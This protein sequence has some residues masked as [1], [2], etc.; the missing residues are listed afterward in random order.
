[1]TCRHCSES[2]PLTWTGYCSRVCELEDIL[3]A[4]FSVEVCVVETPGSSHRVPVG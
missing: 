3:T 4:F 1:M 2:G